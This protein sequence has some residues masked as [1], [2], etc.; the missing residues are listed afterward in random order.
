MI[1]YKRYGAAGC[2]TASSDKYEALLGES[3]TLF[4]SRREVRVQ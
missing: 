2:L 3:K 4:L 1:E